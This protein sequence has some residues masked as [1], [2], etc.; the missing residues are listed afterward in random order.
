MK[1]L[2]VNISDTNGGAA[3]AAYRIH[4]AVN[5]QGVDAK[6]FV[7]NK[8]S[9]D[10]RVFEVADFD[11]KYLFSNQIRFVQNKV[12]NKIQQHRWRPYPDREDVFM[13]DLRSSSIHGAF[14]K[15][16]FD[17]LHL[18]WINLRF[19]NLKELLKVNKPIVW[20]LHDCWAFTG[21]CHYFYDCEKY[22]DS[23][24]E[25][26]FLHSTDKHDLSYQVW[27]KKEHIY[28]KLNLH[29]VTPS[30]WLGEA[31]KQSTLFKN[32]PLTVIPNSIDTE[33]FKPINKT[34]A[35]QK[36]NLDNDK[37]YILYGAMNAVKDSRKGFW[38]LLQAMKFL[39]KKECLNKVE[40][41]VFGA[42]KP[43]EQLQLKIPVS[44]LGVLNNDK[45]II[46]AYNAADVMVV[47]S[48]SE[49]LSNAIME[50]L[51]CGTPVT[52]F[53]IGGNSDMIEHQKNGYLA[54][55]QDSADLANGILWCLENNGKGDL[56]K[57]ARRKVMGNYTNEIVG[58]QYANLY[59]SFYK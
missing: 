14:Q 51:S 46:A 48:L 43:L 55:E 31:A 58:K 3:R 21:V 35:R 2:S 57:N 34:D 53:N 47:P 10:K 44:Y 36:L 38:E 5:E 16:D 20:T 32:F 49:N 1:V 45:D 52:A 33:L 22:K 59:F 11:K 7:K 37:K 56:S 28:G 23:C 9:T 12:K 27:R 30:R 13:S 26:P 41:I 4:Q 25:C 42:D 50:S 29:I 40:L 19:L 6:M 54:K 24:G 15:I 18:H 17:V 39:E 8:N